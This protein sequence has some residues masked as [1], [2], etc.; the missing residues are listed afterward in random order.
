MPEGYVYLGKGPRRSRSEYAEDVVSFDLESPGG[1]ARTV[2]GTVAF[3]D[4]EAETYMVRASNGELIRVPVRDIKATR[5][6]L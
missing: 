6:T 3:L 4:Q 1:Y 2:T 5:R